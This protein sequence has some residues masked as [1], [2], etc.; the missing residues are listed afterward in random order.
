MLSD[1]QGD[2]C[3]YQEVLVQLSLAGRCAGQCVH[4]L[5]ACLWVC[6]TWH[7]ERGR[8]H[9][10]T[11]LMRVAAVS[12]ASMTYERHTAS[13]CMRATCGNWLVSD[14]GVWPTLHC[15][16]ASTYVF[17][18]LVTKLLSLLPGHSS[19]IACTCHPERRPGLTLS[20]R[21]LYPR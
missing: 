13:A 15:Q 4:L 3:Y 16:S 2:V 14:N 17:T 1:V 9:R 11:R 21:G 8:A 10:T 6:W 5:P 12:K 7:A 18:L 20:C 19:T